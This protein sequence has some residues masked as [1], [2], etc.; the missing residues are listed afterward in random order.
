MYLRNENGENKQS[1]RMI[2]FVQ[3]GAIQFEFR[4]AETRALLFVVHVVHTRVHRATLEHEQ[5]ISNKAVVAT[6]RYIVVHKLEMIKSPESS[7]CELCRPPCLN[8]ISVLNHSRFGL[9]TAVQDNVTVDRQGRT[10]GPPK[11]TIRAGTRFVVICEATRELLPS[12]TRRSKTFLTYPLLSSKQYW[13]W[14]HLGPDSAT[15]CVDCVQRLHRWA[16]RSNV[17][18]LNLHQQVDCNL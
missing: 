18:V 2:E 4:V 6:T 14:V 17:A 9:P 8:G 1:R 15:L 16:P 11:E 5:D 3:N 12:P 10:I 7:N 13:E